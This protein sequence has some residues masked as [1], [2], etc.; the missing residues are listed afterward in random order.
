M[1]TVTALEVFVVSGATILAFS[2]RQNARHLAT[3][4]IVVAT[5]VVAATGYILVFTYIDYRIF[6]T[7]G[8]AANY[9]IPAWMW[10]SAWFWARRRE[11]TRYLPNFTAWI[12]SL[13]GSIGIAYLFMAV[14][15]PALW[16]PNQ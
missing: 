3:V 11:E 10:L 8:L 9:I 1:G 12:L 14:W 2:A 4:G 16:L 6:E 15:W 13:A 5:M 7:T